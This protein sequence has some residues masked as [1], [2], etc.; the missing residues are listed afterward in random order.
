MIGFKNRNA[1]RTRIADLLDRP[2]LDTHIVSSFIPLCETDMNRRLRHWRMEKCAVTDLTGDRFALPP[3]WLETVRITVFDGARQSL[4]RQVS[5]TEL[6]ALKEAN[7][8]AVA[9][10]PQVFAMAAGQIE[11]FP[12]PVDTVSVSLYYLAEIPPLSTGTATNWVLQTF[13]DLYVWGSLVPSAPFLRD[14]PRLAMWSGLYEAA[15]EGTNKASRDA[16]HSGAGLRLNM[17]R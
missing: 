14:D 16:K 7:P 17:R 8:E 4:L 5:H 15:M 11:V 12:M 10:R 3:D 13:P 2:D 9:S 1:L 6:I